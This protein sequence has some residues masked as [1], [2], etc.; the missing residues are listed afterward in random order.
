MSQ[1]DDSK[2]RSGDRSLGPA[3][4]ALIA[5]AAVATFAIGYAIARGDDRGAA[6]SGAPAS[7]QP[8]VT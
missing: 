7:D 8:G 2:K 6:E 3:R 5:A 4:Y 1:S